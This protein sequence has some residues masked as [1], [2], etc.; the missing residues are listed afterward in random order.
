MADPSNGD[1]GHPRGPARRTQRDVVDTD[2]LAAG[3]IHHLLV[4]YVLPQEQLAIVEGSLLFGQGAGKN[5]IGSLHAQHL[6]PIHIDQA[7]APSPGSIDPHP[8]LGH[9]WEIRPYPR[10]HVLQPPNSGVGGVEH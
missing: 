2:D 6:R 7:G 4:E 3:N 5:D 10:C 9:A 8:D 1:A